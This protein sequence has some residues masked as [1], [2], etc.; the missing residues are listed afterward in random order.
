M[1]KKI[2]NNGE[3]FRVTVKVVDTALGCELE[4]E[5]RD[6]LEAYEFSLEHNRGNI[7]RVTEAVIRRLMNIVEDE[8]KNE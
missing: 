8:L 7:K 4:Q 2:K 1:E 6:A 5:I 3:K